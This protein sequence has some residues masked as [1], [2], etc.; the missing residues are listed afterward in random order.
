MVVDH[1]AFTFVPYGTPLWTVMDA[2]GKLTGPI[3]FYMAVEGFHHTRSC[4][5]Y[6]SLVAETGIGSADLAGR[7]LLHLIPVSYT[8]LPRASQSTPVRITM[9]RT[10]LRPPRHPSTT[11]IMGMVWARLNMAATVRELSLIHI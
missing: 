4:L 11:T 2:V 1:V 3:M 6:T 8:H 10:E 5:L 9:R 7:G